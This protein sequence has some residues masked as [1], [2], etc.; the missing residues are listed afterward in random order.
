MITI[1]GAT[2]NTG[3]VVA[4]ELLE[5]RE[6]IRVLA[7]DPAKVAGLAARGAEVVQGDVF[8][9]AAVAEALSG[10][11]GAYLLMP[12]DNQSQDLLA[13]N[14]RIAEIFAAGLAKART[15]HAVLLSSVGAQEPSGTGPIVSTH[16]AERA[17]SQ[18][19]GTR[20]T[21]VRAAYF[22]ENILANAHP[23]KNDGVLPVFGGGAGFAF[24]MVATHDIGLVAAA[25]LAS[26]PSATEIVE[27]SGP[28]EYSFEDA[29]ASAAAILGRAVKAVD[30]PLEAVVPTLT[31]FG[32]S[33]NVA[34]LYREMIEGLGSGR[35][36]YDGKGRSVRGKTTLE[37]VLRGAL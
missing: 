37:D 32:F 23:M 36:R 2:G 27:L 11:K 34:G 24:P 6:A 35:V 21:F 30:V 19:E 17:L 28:R 12:P 15:A 8:D 33:A 1:F 5:R 10:A 31:G 14:A 3:A 22:M 7:R 29:A 4:K 20:F 18:V 16:V 26:P 25:A 9:E 13:R